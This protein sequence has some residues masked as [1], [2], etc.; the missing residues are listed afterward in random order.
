MIFIRSISCSGRDASRKLRANISKKSRGLKFDELEM[1]AKVDLP[2]ISLS[3]PVLPNIKLSNSLADDNEFKFNQPLT[4]EQFSLQIAEKTNRKKQKMSLKKTQNTES[5]CSSSF[6]NINQPCNVSTTNNAETKKEKVV[7]VNDDTRTEYLNKNDKA[8]ESY[9]FGDDSSKDTSK[10]LIKDSDSKLEPMKNPSNNIFE[11][12][13]LNIEKSDKTRQICETSKSDNSQKPST[14]SQ[15]NKHSAW[16]SES[17]AIPNKN[18]TDKIIECSKPPEPFK[19]VVEPS[20]NWTCDACWVKNKSD[21]T[22]CISCGTVKPGCVAENKPQPSTQFKFGLNNAFDQSSS[23]SQFKFGFDSNKTD[24][25][26]SQFKFGSA[27]F[28]T[29]ENGK[30]DTPSEFKFG[31]T[32]NT[33]DPPLST[34]KFGIDNTISQATKKPVEVP[35]R[36]NTDQSKSQFKFGFEK[37]SDQPENQF[38]FGQSMTTNKPLAQFKF[39]FNNVD[40]DKPVQQN[41]ASDNI[42][43]AQSVNEF[44]SLVNNKNEIPEKSAESP[45]KSI[46]FKFGDKSI[47]QVTFSSVETNS[48]NIGLK[49]DESSKGKCVWD[50]KDKIE[51]KPISSG[52]SP[53]VQSV[54]NTKSVQLVN[55]HS[56]SNETLNEDQKP[57]FKLPQIFSFSSLAAKQ[58]QNLPDDQKKNKTFTFGSATNDNKSFVAPALNSGSFTNTNTVF[59]ANNSMFSSSSSA[60]T[61]LGSSTPQFS[62]GSMAPATNSLFSKTAKDNDKKSSAQTLNSFTSTN[63]GFSF[64]T[65]SPPTFSVANASGF[66]KSSIPVI[67][68]N[69]YLTSFRK[70]EFYDINVLKF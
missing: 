17:F 39:G 40:A 60:V 52:M 34:F 50:K 20:C 66:M 35:N 32:N 53:T 22:S 25:S 57:A 28:Q 59:G 49:N 42:K 51:V 56:H 61:T 24:Q 23:A 2:N 38:K 4:L 33:T 13:S 41:V 15:P 43:V 6:T 65:P 14:V 62:F 12:S 26:S 55:G 68:Q 30:S 1:P 46:Q 9:K 10:N 44:K 70:F 45:N 36:N 19:K 29:L 63:I 64:G 21:C 67:K 5:K 54:D 7:T 27:A 69:I 37:K 58:D 31:L 48:N 16:N 47:P 11:N 18:E 8:L 3:M